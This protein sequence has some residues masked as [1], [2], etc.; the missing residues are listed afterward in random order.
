MNSEARS[1]L[2]ILTTVIAIGLVVMYSAS[3]ITAFKWPYP[4]FDYYLKRQVFAI[5]VGFVAM[6][7][8]SIVDYKTHRRFIL[9]YYMLVF[10]LLVIALAFPGKGGSRRWIDLGYFD[11]Q[12]SELAKLLIILFVAHYADKQRVHM[13]TFVKGFIV[14]TSFIGVLLLLVFV[15]PDLSTTIYL[16]LLF[17]IMLYVGGTRGI[18]ILLMIGLG[19]SLFFLA[20]KFELLKDYQIE[21]IESFVDVITGKINSTWHQASSSINAVKN[22][23]FIGL[24][25]GLGELKYYI[26]V[27]F[28]DFIFAVLGEE[29]GFVGISGLLIL[30]VLMVRQMLKAAFESIKDDFGR[31]LTIG[32]AFMVLLQVTINISVVLGILPTTGLTLPFVSYG[33]SSILVFLTGYGIVLSVLTHQ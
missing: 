15:E 32:Y 14:P 16:T 9:H 5:F 30:Y 11:L 13:K 27:Q 2:L 31:M 12:P 28:S 26:P 21:R 20:Y 17:L 25:L 24:G 23:G 6:L 1:L 10:A 19:I 18:Y 7:I 29:L 33:G 8:A 3:Y 22:G 4:D